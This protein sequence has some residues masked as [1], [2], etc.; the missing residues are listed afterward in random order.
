VIGVKLMGGLGN[1]MFQVAAIEALSQRQESPVD[2]I[3]S[4]LDH[5]LSMQGNAVLTYRD[6]IFRK[7]NLVETPLQF[8][9]VYN[10]P[11]FSYEELP[12]VENIIYEGYFQSEKYFIDFSDHIRDLYSPTLE[13]KNSIMKKYSHIDF[14]SATSL[15]IR[16]GDYV[17]LPD[18]HPV[19]SLQYYES[20]LSKLSELRQVLIFSDDS[21][22]C[23]DNFAEG[24]DFYFIE[25]E[26]DYIDLY[27]MS[28]CKNNI[29]ANSSFS[30]WAAWLNE[31]LNKQIIA[32]S[33]W[34]GPSDPQ[35]TQDLV[36]EEWDRI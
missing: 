11:Y 22:W 10:R 34:F 6:N 28:L 2:F 17:N 26:K 3:V 7:I 23:K 35:D 29:I 30:W 15:H 36:P 16:R 19:C 31:H 1:Q 14:P 24:H 5:H 9:G 25:N 27:M 33:V 21:D 18:N 12:Y 32:P 4:S 20:A 8:E 13:I